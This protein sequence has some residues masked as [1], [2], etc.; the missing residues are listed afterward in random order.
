MQCEGDVCVA[1]A[2]GSGN[3]H[4]VTSEG[5]DPSWAPDS[6]RVVFEHYLYGGTVYGARPRSLSIVDVNGEDLRKLTFGPSFARKPLRYHYAI[7]IEQPPV[8]PVKT[9]VSRGDDLNVIVSSADLPR[10]SAVRFQLC[11]NQTD[12]EHCT[13][14]RIDSGYYM[15]GWTVDAGE[16]VA[17]TFRLSVRV[18]GREVAYANASLRGS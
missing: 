13:Q 12:G 9:T 17:G 1:D 8:G 6:R 5:G 16:G 15:T 10:D 11:V 3:G 18:Q 7:R 2:D 4:R 14:E